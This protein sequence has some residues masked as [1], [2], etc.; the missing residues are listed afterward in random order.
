MSD[1]PTISQQ[2]ADLTPE[3]RKALYADLV[4]AEEARN[5]TDPSVDTLSLL[6]A[7]VTLGSVEIPPLSFGALAILEETGNGLLREDA[8]IEHA[9]MLDVVEILFVAANQ[10]TALPLVYRLS[11]GKRAIE[12]ARDLAET[13]P[14]HYRQYLDAR[15]AL[16]QDIADQWQE[17]L[18]EFALKLATVK[19][20]DVRA[21]AKGVLEDALSPFGSAGSACTT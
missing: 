3:A 5:S 17:L 4:K 20:S 8:D 12:D 13:S 19:P 10:D 14:E 18:D 16:V 15:S 11:R 1:Q 7:S 6:G 21:A 9:S 2:V